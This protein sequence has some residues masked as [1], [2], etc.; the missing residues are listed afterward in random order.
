[1]TR[2]DDR[3]HESNRSTAARTRRPATG[4]WPPD[5]AAERLRCPPSGRPGALQDPVDLLANARTNIYAIE[6]DRASEDI[7]VN[8]AEVELDLETRGDKHIAELLDAM[9][10]AGYEVEVLIRTPNDRLPACPGAA[11]GEVSRDGPG[12][13][14]ADEPAWGSVQMRDVEL[15]WRQ[16]G[17]RKPPGSQ[18]PRLAVSGNQ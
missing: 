17:S 16:G 15:E 1:M 2:R 11:G 12:H 13:T 18:P 4:E 5:A 10:A 6:H 8:A 7:A 9:E 3:P 14:I